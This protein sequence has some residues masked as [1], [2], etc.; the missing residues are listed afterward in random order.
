MG[1]GG[2]VCLCEIVCVYTCACLCAFLCGCMCV[3]HTCVFVCVCVT[4]STTFEPVLMCTLCVSCLL[5]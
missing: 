1:V 3:Q 5:N 4:Q 2:C